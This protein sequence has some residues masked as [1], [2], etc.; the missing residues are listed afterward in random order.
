MGAPWEIARNRLRRNH[1][2]STQNHRRDKRAPKPKENFSMDT[3]M[4]NWV[5]TRA[6]IIGRLYYVNYNTF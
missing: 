6:P 2:A 1:V 3:K 5:L 4:E